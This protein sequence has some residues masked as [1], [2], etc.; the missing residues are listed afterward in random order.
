MLGL[1]ADD[2]SKLRDLLRCM[3]WS[4][5]IPTSQDDSA[6]EQVVAMDIPSSTEDAC[7]DVDMP[8][9]DQ[10]GVPLSLLCSDDEVEAP[11]A[12]PVLDQ[13]L[14]TTSA[15]S[16]TT[17]KM[18]GSLF[19]ISCGFRLDRGFFVP[20]LDCSSAHRSALHCRC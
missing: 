7:S 17:A 9:C 4:A 3:Q 8:D 16:L 6:D 1:G 15:H 5:D 20:A 12:Q 2:R 19:F 18:A 13:P 11:D 14:A 10:H